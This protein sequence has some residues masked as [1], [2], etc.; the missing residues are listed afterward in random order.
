MMANFKS[1]LIAFCVLCV[2]VVSVFSQEAPPAP[3]A[4]KTVAVPA[5]QEALRLL[6]LTRR[7][8]AGPDRLTS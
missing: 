1:N 6:A 4:P 2:S 3:G 7:R 8:G 5:V